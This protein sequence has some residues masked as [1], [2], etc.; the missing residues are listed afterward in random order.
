MEDRSNP[1]HF[2]LITAGVLCL[3]KRGCLLGMEGWKDGGMDR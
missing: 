3:A 2:P 1:N